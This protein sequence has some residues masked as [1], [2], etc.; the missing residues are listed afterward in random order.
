VLQVID[1]YGDDGRF[2]ESREVRWEKRAEGKHVLGTNRR[3][4]Y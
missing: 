1:V 2:T 3:I 4:F